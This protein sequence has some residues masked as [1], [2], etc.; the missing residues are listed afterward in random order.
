MEVSAVAPVGAV[1]VKVQMIHILEA[2]TPNGGALWWDDVSLSKDGS[3]VS[4]V[5]IS[6]YESLKFGIDTSAI[7]TFADLKVQLED[8]AVNPGVFS[9]ARKA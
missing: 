8:G 3:V 9:R 7:G 6:T 5:D 4:G 1:E 2:S